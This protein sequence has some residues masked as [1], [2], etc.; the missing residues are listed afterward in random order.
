RPMSAWSGRKETACRTGSF[1]PGGLEPFPRTGGFPRATST[2]DRRTQPPPAAPAGGA[3]TTVEPEPET[4]HHPE[5][6]PRLDP[7]VRQLTN[8]IHQAADRDSPSASQPHGE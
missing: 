2:V 4:G 3:D 1:Q 7:F 8:P 5:L 6:H